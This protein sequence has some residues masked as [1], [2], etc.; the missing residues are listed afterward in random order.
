MKG[1]ELVHH[2]KGPP[3]IDRTTY[4][5]ESLRELVRLPTWAGKMYHLTAFLCTT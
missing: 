5:K 2:K 3:L 1:S 4:M